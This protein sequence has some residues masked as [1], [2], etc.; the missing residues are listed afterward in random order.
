MEKFLSL[1]PV[2]QFETRYSADI[3]DKTYFGFPLVPL[4]AAEEILLKI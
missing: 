4:L 3:T 2:D 1:V